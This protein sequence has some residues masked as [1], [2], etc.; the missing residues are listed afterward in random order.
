VNMGSLVTTANLPK[1]LIFQ[2]AGCILVPCQRI[3]YI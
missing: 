3:I 1:M 2:P